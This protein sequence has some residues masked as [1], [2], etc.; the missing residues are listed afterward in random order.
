M[1]IAVKG[2]RR[3]FSVLNQLS[4]CTSLRL[5]ASIRARDSLYQIM[6]VMT[7]AVVSI[8]IICRFQALRCDNL[9]GTLFVQKPSTMTIY[10]HATCPDVLLAVSFTKRPAPSPPCPLDVS[11]SCRDSDYVS[12]AVD[13]NS[14][15]IECMVIRSRRRNSIAP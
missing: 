5:S 4:I 8:I 1:I 15:E 3:T 12:V 14:F 9:H 2:M 7:P 13:R 11:V 6:H 10:R